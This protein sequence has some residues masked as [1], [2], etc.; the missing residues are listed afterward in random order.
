M[1]WLW[2]VALAFVLKEVA[3]GASAADQPKLCASVDSALNTHV[4][5][6]AQPGVDSVA[7]AVVGDI[8]LALEDTADL[9]RVT[10]DLIAGNYGTALTDLET[11]FVKVVTPTSPLTLAAIKAARAGV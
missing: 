10:G 9:A 8:F 7:N 3:A 1:P 2:S 4:P 5:P 11:L 6:F